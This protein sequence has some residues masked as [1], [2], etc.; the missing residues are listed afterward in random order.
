MHKI[1]N[2]SLKNYLFL[3]KLSPYSLSEIIQLWPILLIYYYNLVII[4]D[5]ISFTH[6]NNVMCRV[7]YFTLK[8]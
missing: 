2:L 4:L 1:L 8:Y 3:L 5:M 7:I 6:F